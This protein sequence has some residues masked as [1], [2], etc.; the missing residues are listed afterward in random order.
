MSSYP[1]II[2]THLTG[3]AVS[4]INGVIA[5]SIISF[6]YAI[7]LY[8][9]YL[10]RYKQTPT[11]K[12]IENYKKY[13]GD[14]RGTIIYGLYSFQELIEKQTLSDN[15]TLSDNTFT[16][17]IPGLKYIYNLIISLLVLLIMLF[18]NIVKVFFTRM[19][20]TTI[21][22]IILYMYY[23]AYIVYN[24][25]LFSGKNTDIL[26]DIFS[27][28]IYKTTTSNS[29]I[30]T[31]IDKEGVTRDYTLK[32]YYINA[33][34]APYTLGD[35]TRLPST[36]SLQ[37]IV[38]A[39][40]RYMTFD[41][42]EDIISTGEI[43]GSDYD[44]QYIPNVRNSY[45]Y[46][47][48]DSNLARD[49]GIHFDYMMQALAYTKPFSQNPDYPLIIHLNFWNQDNKNI[50]RPGFKNKATYDAVYTSIN[51]YFKDKLGLKGSHYH[52]Y[53]GLSNVDG[54]FSN[55]KMSE[56]RGRLLLVSNIN[57]QTDQQIATLAQY[58]YG[59]INMPIPDK[60]KDKKV[61]TELNP[62]PLFLPY[63]YTKDLYDRGGITAGKDGTT[64]NDFIDFNK[65]GI[66]LIIPEDC[67]D[68]KLT[69]KIL[70]RQNTYN[71]H[72]LDCMNTGCQI[73]LMNFQYMNIDLQNNQQIFD[74]ASFILK[75]EIL[76]GADPK[77]CKK[78]IQSPEVSYAPRSYSLKGI[79]DEP[80]V[81]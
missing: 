51:K 5:I 71:P 47:T 26:L 46:K 12:T 66:R 6:V 37:Y 61:E 72:I 55:I 80:I 13:Y 36:K 73:V 49:K 4:I 63:I 21:L 29:P 69:R 31:Y 43:G 25:N 58:L 62:D 39:G 76:R 1:T 78:T 59:T 45:M 19:T 27:S 52:G 3:K 41:I 67:I 42:F 53:G 70:L 75:P 56:C 9:I 11:T 22:A 54:S 65:K 38:N 35:N 20:L 16:K 57:P 23:R 60:F 30:Y 8:C 28:S 15:N 77:P 50:I 40:A 32:D 44:S 79:Q 34:K 7:E 74:K 17:Y 18:K 33:V 81:F 2:G 14:K 68:S 64:I 24:T 48:D 10:D